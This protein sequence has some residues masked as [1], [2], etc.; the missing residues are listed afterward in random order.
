MTCPHSF[1]WVAMAV[2]CVALPVRAA[3]NT[4]P[5]GFIALFNGRDLSGW[6]DDKTGHW[7]AV[8][9][10]LVY[11]GQGDHLVTA[12]SYGDFVLLLDWKIQDGGNSGIFL[13]SD[14]QVEIWDNRDYGTDMGS[15]GIVPYT[16]VKPIN[17]ADAPIGEWNHFEIRVEKGAVTVLLNDQLVVDKRAMKFT[18]S[19][20]P[21]FLQHHS[22]PL[23]FKNIYIKK[24]P[25][26]A[27]SVS[28][29]R[30]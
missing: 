1:K 14:V 29:N 22:S 10:E 12:E 20:A 13:R 19:Q 6:N 3:D 4:P 2:V 18:K 21:F 16:D 5:E 9:G 23:W 26:A 24:L 25:C 15:G 27:D 8:N 28:G 7:Q 30:K 11:N 17:D